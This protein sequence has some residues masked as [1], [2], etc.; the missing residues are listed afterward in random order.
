[1]SAQAMPEDGPR[2]SDRGPMLVAVTDHAAERF[3][4]R[5]RGTLD[6]KTEIRIVHS[7]GTTGKLSFLPR[8]LNE[9]PAYH[10]AFR[11]LFLPYKGEQGFDIMAR[12]I[13]FVHFGY[14]KG[15]SSVGR[16]MESLLA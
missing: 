9:M 5:V 10:A 2:S 12:P 15:T 7:S 14:R 1:M 13:P 4:Q 6:A 11:S 3:R 8:S 16:R